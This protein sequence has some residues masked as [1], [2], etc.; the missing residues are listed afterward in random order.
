MFNFMLRGGAMEA[1]RLQQRLQRAPFGEDYIPKKGAATCVIPDLR[2]PFRL[3]T[4]F[5][6]DSLPATAAHQ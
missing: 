3:L 5:I 1:G 4:L 2:R 6:H